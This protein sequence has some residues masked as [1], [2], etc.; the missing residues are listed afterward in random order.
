MINVTKHALLRY[1][2]RFKGVDKNEVEQ[3]IN[4]NKDQYINELNKMFDNSRL[5]YSGKFNVKHTDTNFR[6][7]DNIILITDVID[8]KIITLYRIDFGFDR[9]VDCSII[10]SLIKKLDIAE[11]KYISIM[12]NVKTEKDKLLSQRD[13]LKIEIDTLKG[14]LNSMNESL[15]SMDEYIKNFGYEETQAKTDMDLIAKKIVYSNVYRK[16]MMECM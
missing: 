2:Q 15:K 8:S 16:E 3:S 1:V 6:M 7:V 14:T 11:E 5:I 13:S 4:L 12:E 10:D 9:D